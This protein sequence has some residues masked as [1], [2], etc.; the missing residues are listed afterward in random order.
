MAQY[1]EGKLISNILIEF[2][3]RRKQWKE[4]KTEIQTKKN[5]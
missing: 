2:Q 4:T 1:K 3:T 5:T